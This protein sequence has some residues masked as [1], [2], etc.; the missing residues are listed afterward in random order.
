LDWITLLGKLEF[1]NALD[2]ARSALGSWPIATHLS[3][4]NEVK[5][6]ADAL[7]SVSDGIAAERL[8]DAIPVLISW[9]KQDDEFP[10]AAFQEVYE[11]LWTLLILGVRRGRSERDSTAV[12]FDTILSLGLKEKRYGEVLRDALDIAGEPGR[13][14]AYWMLSLV[15][16]TV[17]Q[18]APSGDARANFWA[19]A[20][21]RLEP[22]KP[23]LSSLQRVALS[24][25][26]ESLNIHTSAIAST[27]GDVRDEQVSA[28]L[29]GKKVAIYTLTERAGY[30]AINVLRS[31]AP[32]A[33]F[34]LHTDY[35][36]SVT[37]KN[38]AET[39]DIFVMVTASAKHAATDFISSHRPRNKPTLYAPG[40]GMSGIIRVIDEF[41]AS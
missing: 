6:L 19:A 2:V 35:V 15:E 4:S 20:F 24:A 25:L 10:R 41:F 3:Q 8:A 27:T 39:A 5:R 21:Y 30:Q 36:G 22:L 13:S 26:A 14:T 9:L 29:A 12:L 33:T 23:H 16:T 28:A 38:A 31:L 17:E 11:A 40:R 1:S 18:Q 32:H 37:L 34:S 7:L